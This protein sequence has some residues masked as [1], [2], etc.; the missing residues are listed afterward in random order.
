MSVRLS[1]YAACLLL[2]WGITFSHTLSVP[3]ISYGHKLIATS[4]S[5][6]ATA[7]ADPVTMQIVG[8]VFLGRAVERSMKVAGY[9]YPYRGLPLDFFVSDIVLANFESAIPATHVPTP[10]FGWRFSVRSDVLPAFKMAG[11]THVSLANN[12]SYDFGLTGFLSTK[13]TLQAAGIT[14]LGGST[15]A[16]STVHYERIR[17]EKI[18]LVTLSTVGTELSVA[19]LTSIMEAVDD[20]T[21]YT[22]VYLHWGEEYKHAHSDYQAT[23]ATTLIDLGADAI[24]GHHPHVVQGIGWYKEVPIFYSLGNFIFDQY[25]SQ[26]VQEGLTLA[27]T[28]ASSTVQYTLQ[29]VTSV[30]ARHQPRLLSDNE[31]RRFLN[32]LA[33]R[34]QESL[35]EQVSAGVIL[36]ER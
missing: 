33:R 12:H 13:D 32:D 30:A 7:T 34:S 9:D 26:S 31:K 15:S 3:A 17:D 20:D 5:S 29:P 2:L 35:A 1:L 16:T 21:T 11:I 18:A 27:V 6:V 28:L 24:V 4:S 8:D 23:V 36:Q 22:L 10:D 25:F 19:E 14:P